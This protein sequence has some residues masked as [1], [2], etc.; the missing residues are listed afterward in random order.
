MDSRPLFTSFPASNPQPNLFFT[1]QGNRPTREKLHLVPPLAT[2]TTAS[3]LL[4]LLLL[5]PR[6]PPREHQVQLRQQRPTPAT[7]M[8]LLLAPLELLR[9]RLRNLTPPAVVAGTL[10]ALANLKLAEAAAAVIVVVAPEGVPRAEGERRRVGGEEGG[11]GA[12]AARRR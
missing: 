8:L 11:E 9:H 12:G 5:R 4:L 2:T 1:E 10:A 6:L 7:A 3:M